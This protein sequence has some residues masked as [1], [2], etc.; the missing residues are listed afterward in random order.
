MIPSPLSTFFKLTGLLF[1]ALAEGEMTSE[2]NRLELKKAG[3][4][5]DEY[6]V[7]CLQ[8]A[9]LGRMGPSW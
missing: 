2:D 6:D 8:S 5:P 9:W 7:F 4:R 1:A 3:Q